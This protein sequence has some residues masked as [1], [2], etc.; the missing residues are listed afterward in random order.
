MVDRLHNMCALGT[1]LMLLG[2][3]FAAAPARADEP[4]PGHAL[5]QV[6]FD[7]Q[8]GA[9]VPRDLRFR[10]ETGKAVRIGDYLGARPVILVLAYY[11]C[12]NLC[13]TVIN[14]MVENLRE[15]NFTLG[16]Q[17]DVVTVS[18]DPRETPEI[19]A[20]KRESFVR[21]YGRAGVEAGW[22]ALTGDQAAITRLADTVGFRYIYDQTVQQY[23]HPSG[24][25]LLTPEGKI[26]RYLYGLV[27]SPTDLRLGLVEA[28]ANK[29][30]S[31]VD[32]VLLRC[33]RYDPVAGKYSF[34]IMSFV[35]GIGAVTAA[36]L[37]GFMVM[38]IRRERRRMSYEF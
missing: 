22:H 1:L 24:L 36:I 15:L 10:D 32:Q 20:E 34:A 28:S 16:K 2:W 30:G 25:I 6:R 33:L 13:S 26:S 23:A 31:V 17:F 14:D 19:A 18:I 12:P 27:Y 9:Q 7:Q 21:N 3:L 38:T 35:R 37:G 29:I 11:N 5:E 4:G 8:P